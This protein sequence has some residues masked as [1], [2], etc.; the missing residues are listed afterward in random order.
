[1]NRALA[2]LFF[3]LFLAGFA[4]V[5]LKNMGSTG[6]PGST[7]ERNTLSISSGDWHLAALGPDHDEKVFVRF[8]ADGSVSGFA[9]CNSFFGTY[10][11]TGRKLEIGQLGATR[12]A[13]PESVMQGESSFMG[14]LQAASGYQVN[15]DTLILSDQQ[16]RTTRLVL[17]A[18]AIDQ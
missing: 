3:M 4:L 16:G 1:M 12:M 5:M 13:C 6:A 10:I 15:G 8:L 9:G 7:I 11:A 2:F 14:A 17:L 18:A